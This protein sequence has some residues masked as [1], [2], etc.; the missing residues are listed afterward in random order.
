MQ[1]LEK[2]PAGGEVR[3]SFSQDQY[4]FHV[5]ASGGLVYLALTDNAAGKRVAFAFLD[6]VKAKFGM[7]FGDGAAKA[8]A[9][10]VSFSYGCSLRTGR[11]CRWSAIQPQA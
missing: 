3:N 4:L 9:Y 7:R 2:V 11:G 1:L 6:D 5:L 10:Q 8:I